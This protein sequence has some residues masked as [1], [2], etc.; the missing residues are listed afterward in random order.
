MAPRQNESARMPLYR[1]PESPYWWVRFSVGGIKVRRSS[2]TTDRHA[3]EEFEARLRADLWRQVRLGERPRYT[4]AEAVERWYRE[5][6]TRERDRERERL[7]W[8][9]PYLDEV[10]LAEIGRDLIEKLRSVRA[11]ESSPSTANRYMALLRNVL[12]KAHREWDW[13]DRAPVVPMY[14]LETSEPRYLTRN[15]FAALKKELPAHLADLAEF[16]VETGL[17]MR[18]TTGLTWAQVDL[19]RGQ[20]MIPAARAKAGETIA[21]PLSRRALAIL[22]A[23]RGEHETH[24]FTFRGRPTSDANGAAFKQ[25]AK[26]AGLPWLRWHDLRHTW[27]SWHIQA[28]TPP[29]VLR[30]LGAWKSDAMVRRYAHL[31]TEHLR[32]FAEHGKGTARRGRGKSRGKGGT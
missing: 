15:Q 11:A 21:L 24:V 1:H 4:W 30:E 18:N 31:S 22:K 17:R 3:A 32:A 16:S 6:D 19:R 27:A 8:F 26:K 20:L 2:Q 9:A 12:R 29:H 14:R 13:I 23:K 25:A 28:G 7:K 10:P 5:C